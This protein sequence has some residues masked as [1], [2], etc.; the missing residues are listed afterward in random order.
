M[1]MTESIKNKQSVNPNADSLHT[2]R[3]N[4][5]APHEFDHQVSFPIMENQDTKNE[6]KKD[7]LSIMQLFIRYLRSL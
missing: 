2:K 4:P 7:K 1:Y 3:P 5:N 6:V